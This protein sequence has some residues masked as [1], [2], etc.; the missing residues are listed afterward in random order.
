M[1]ASSSSGATNEVHDPIVAPPARQGESDVTQSNPENTTIPQPYGMDSK[2]T[3]PPE[4]ISFSDQDVSRGQ[5]A[6]SES[7]RGSPDA[8]EPSHENV[9]HPPDYHDEGMDATHASQNF[10]QTGQHYPMSLD[11]SKSP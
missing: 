1:E 3:L 7:W 2:E 5:A 8:T 11:V 9:S 4:S 6:P 10:V